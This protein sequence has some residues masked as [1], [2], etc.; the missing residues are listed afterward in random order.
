MPRQPACAPVEA[1]T[2]HPNA[3]T[4]CRSDVKFESCSQAFALRRP[5]PTHPPTRPPFN[6]SPLAT[7]TTILERS[8]RLLFPT[9]NPT[10]TPHLPLPSQ[11]WDRSP[12]CVP[13]PHSHFHPHFPPLSQVWALLPGFC[14]A[15]PDVRSRPPLYW[16]LCL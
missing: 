3:L 11:V 1:P 8:P 10:L 5:T 4:T 16:S 7:T 2:S 14:A 15:A 9:V 6:P 12:T 13:H